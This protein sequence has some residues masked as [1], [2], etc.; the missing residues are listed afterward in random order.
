MKSGHGSLRT[1]RTWVGGTTTTSF[2]FSF[3][4]VALAPLYRS[5]ENFTSSGVTGEPSWNLAFFRMVKVYVRWS[6]DS[7]HDSARL[8][9]VMPAGIGFTIASWMAYMTMY[10]VLNASVSAGSSHLA[11]SVTCSPQ[12]SSPSAARE[13]PGYSGEATTATRT[14]MRR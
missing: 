8:G 4:S 14:A 10:G 12:R 2:T 9:V 6:R 1:K 7:F 5:K 13:A 11:A 3:R